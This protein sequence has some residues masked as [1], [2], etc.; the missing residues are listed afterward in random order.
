MAADGEEDMD[1]PCDPDWG[2]LEP[3][4]TALAQTKGSVA[5]SGEHTPESNE[6]SMQA[7]P[8]EACE[9]DAAYDPE[10]NHM[11]PP[12]GESSQVN[13]CVNEDMH[14]MC[15]GSQEALFMQVDGGRKKCFVFFMPYNLCAN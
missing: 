1:P 2:Y 3:P 10:H 9:G 6:T 13:S 15:I 8:E 5:A 11:V 12:Q 7:E 14:D 4:R